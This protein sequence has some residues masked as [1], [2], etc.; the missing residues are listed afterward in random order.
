MLDIPF[1]ERDL[2]RLSGAE[3]AALYPEEASRIASKVTGPRP[4][5]PR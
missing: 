3:A 1:P 2:Y 5:T 4:S